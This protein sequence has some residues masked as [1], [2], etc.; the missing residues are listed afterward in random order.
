LFC[1]FIDLYEYLVRKRDVVWANF[2]IHEYDGG[3][4]GFLNKIFNPSYELE[5]DH[6]N[7]K[8]FVGC[9]DLVHAWKMKAAIDP[10][11]VTPDDPA[12]K[13]AFKSVVCCPYCSNDI[14]F[15]D[16]V[17]NKGIAMR[18]RCPVCQTEPTVQHAF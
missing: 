13:A 1:S 17:I 11:I 15:G 9:V 10:D 14:L 16:A 3:I 8:S 2:I 18:I 4:M 5:L 12:L 6:N 7:D